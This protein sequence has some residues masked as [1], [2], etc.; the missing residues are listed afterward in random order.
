MVRVGSGKVTVVADRQLGA[1]V[2]DVRRFTVR[3][4]SVASHVDSGVLYVTAAGS[5]NASDLAAKNRLTALGF[6]VIVKDGPSAVSGDDA[7]KV[8]EPRG[9]RGPRPR[10]QAPQP[11]VQPPHG[12]SPL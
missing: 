2:A 5:L 8:R 10:L 12:G 9:A 4:P 6:N 7:G 1:A 11:A 3:K